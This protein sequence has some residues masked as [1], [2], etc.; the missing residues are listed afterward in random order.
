MMKKDVKNMVDV[1]DYLTTELKKVP[2]Y[3]QNLYK[4]TSHPAIL[5]QDI[6]W[7]IPTSENLDCP[8]CREEDP[9]DIF[10]DGDTFIYVDPCGYLR[11]GNSDNVGVIDI[12]F[13]PMCGQQLK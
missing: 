10:Y 2:V 5:K 8:F 7:D 1:M 9:Q 11:F 12:M 3:L 6:G 13:C 4:V